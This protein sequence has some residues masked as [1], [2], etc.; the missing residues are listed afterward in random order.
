MINK[1][2]K[3]TLL[4][5]TLLTLCVSTSKGQDSLSLSKYIQPARQ[6]NIFKTEGYYNW[7]G[8]VVKGEDGK[9][10]LFYSRWPKS[11]QFSGWMVYS[12]IA[13]AVSDQ[14]TGPWEYKETVL[15]GRGKG[16]WDAIT[17]HNPKIKCFE[18]K[19]YLYYISTNLGENEDY[20]ED[21]LREISHSRMSHPGRKAARSNQRTGVA[22]ATSLN[23]P[24]IRQNQPLIE[25][26]GPITTLTV[27]PAVDQGKDDRYYMIVKGDKPNETRFIRNQAMA[28]SDHPD[29]PYEIQPDPVI[30]YIDT[31]DMSL[32]FDES[33]S[34]YYGIFHTP[35]GFIGLVSSVDGVKWKK[36]SEYQV[37]PKEIKMEDGSIL[38]PDRLERPFVY[39]ENGKVIM[40][41]L[42][43]KQGNDSFVITIPLKY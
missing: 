18:G 1:E 38:K 34:R 25:P 3:I 6:E 43:A 22:V 13:H 7:G 30:D 11:T 12:E 28:I 14:P 4:S 39:E 37:M 10:H 40:L 42:A 32:W 8:S 31:E 33:R 16:Y 27:N 17:A 36:A 26:S 9:Y 23:G 5:V 21:D 20:T 24:W 19:F 2:L 41:G 15:E 35:E 29:G